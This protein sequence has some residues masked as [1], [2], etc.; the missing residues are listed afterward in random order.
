MSCNEASSPPPEP[1]HLSHY[2]SLRSQWDVSF[3][4]QFAGEKAALILCWRGPS[5][6][7]APP[8]RLRL[9]CGANTG[10]QSG[11]AHIWVSVHSSSWE[12]LYVV[13]P[14]SQPNRL[15]SN[16]CKPYYFNGLLSN[17]TY[18]RLCWMRVCKSCQM[19]RE[20][21]PEEQ[22]RVS[23]CMRRRLNQTDCNIRRD[24][25][26][27]FVTFGPIFTLS[28]S[29]HHGCDDSKLTQRDTS[30]CQSQLIWQHPTQLF[31]LCVCFCADVGQ[32]LS[33]A[34]P[35]WRRCALTVILLWFSPDI[36]ELRI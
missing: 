20:V 17:G 31:G 5:S 9:C 14:K 28:H 36:N 22:L 7:P 2:S 34:T 24:G 27:V 35:A 26:L 18:I 16:R 12:N 30:S 29:A 25:G 19:R 6:H 23:L 32:M 1:S 3:I 15:Y 13:W 10:R 4:L 33:G 8:S 11:R 21:K